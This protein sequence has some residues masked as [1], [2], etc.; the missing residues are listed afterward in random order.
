MKVSCILVSHDKP[1]LL[2]ESVVSVIEQSYKDWQLIIVDSGKLIDS[3]FFNDKI[4]YDNR[5]EIYRSD[6][7]DELKKTKNMASWCYNEVFKRNLVKG[8][9]VVYLCD[10]D[11]FYENAFF[12]F[13]EHFKRNQ[14]HFAAY[15][16]EDVAVY[17]IGEEPIIY[18]E[19]KALEISGLGAYPM[20][21]RV[22]YLQFCHKIQALKFFSN[23][24][25]WMESKMYEKHADGIFMD[26]IGRHCLIYPIFVKIGMNRRTEGSKN[27]PLHI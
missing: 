16:S 19:R 11:I 20:D 3:S 10:D 1:D 22:D 25:Y 9:L 18:G 4:F 17:R 27:Y 12:T 2:L 23:N 21:C 26:E 13:V 7:N 8:D 5:I 24:E 6:E 14:D 15:A